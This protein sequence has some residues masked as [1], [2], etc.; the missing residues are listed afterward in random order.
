MAQMNSLELDSDDEFKPP[1]KL[2]RRIK[3][4][5]S[6][7]PRGETG[8]DNK[9]HDSKGDDSKNADRNRKRGKNDDNEKHKDDR[10]EL[11]GEK[12]DEKTK[13]ESVRGR[14]ED[15]DD[16]DKRVA[17]GKTTDS[18]KNDDKCAK[19]VSREFTAKAP[20]D[21][22]SVKP[23]KSQ[24]TEDNLI[25][26]QSTTKI[27]ASVFGLK[28]VDDDDDN[29]D[30][31]DDDDNGKSAV[32]HRQDIVI[33]SPESQPRLVRHQDQTNSLASTSINI[34]DLLKNNH[35]GKSK[36]S[37]ETHQTGEDSSSEAGGGDSGS[38]RSGGGCSDSGKND[39]GECGSG[40][41]GT[42]IGMGGR[43]GSG[44]DGGGSNGSG[45]DGGGNNGS[46]MDG[47]GSNGS[48]MNGG[49]SNGSGITE[50][51]KCPSCSSCFSSRCYEDHVKKCLERKFRFTKSKSKS[52]R[53]NSPDSR[54]DHRVEAN[55]PVSLKLK[56]LTKLDV[57][58]IEKNVDLA[59]QIKNPKGQG[60]DKEE[61]EEKGREKEKKE[62]ERKKEG[63][64]IKEGERKKEEAYF[65]SGMREEQNNKRTKRE[66]GSNRNDPLL[67]F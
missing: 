29:N 17:V 59:G 13:K 64:R 20:K 9:G 46:G 41:N 12:K 3:K 1:K 40:S 19:D 7:N 30:D 60:K 27:V 15:D 44:M 2:G 66:E 43:N 56:D 37:K 33:S 61:E 52:S 54:V 28:H 35:L 8:D 4:T 14:N 26:A 22:K 57:D 36:T 45:M 10:K 18:V 63:E 58:N 6:R 34:F 11:K 48:G 55:S 31:D 21:E 39:S 5:Q 47:G 62:D 51:R 24:K 42:G 23:I 67:K 25:T 38:R 53:F 50:E 65:A 16:N 32:M 49:G